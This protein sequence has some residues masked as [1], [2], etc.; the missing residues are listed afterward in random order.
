MLEPHHIKITAPHDVCGEFV[1]R[2]R[3]DGRTGLTNV[4]DIRRTQQCG[5]IPG[6]FSAARPRVYDPAAQSP[7]S[8]AR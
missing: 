3:F 8:S 1:I 5:F 4:I 2:L 7:C 6:E